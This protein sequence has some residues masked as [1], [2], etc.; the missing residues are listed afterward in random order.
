[1]R[2]ATAF[3]TASD[4]FSRIIVLVACNLFGTTYCGGT[5]YGTVFEIVKTGNAYA[6][7]PVTL[8]SFNRK[9]GANPNGSLIFDVNGNL[10][11]TTT[12]GTNNYGTVFQIVNTADAS[13]FI[14]LVNFN[15]SNGALPYGDLL[16]MPTATCSASHTA[17][18][19]STAQYSR[20]LR[21]GDRL[22]EV[23]RGFVGHRNLR[24]RCLGRST[25]RAADCR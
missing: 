4:E 24:V 1:M 5:G 9:N 25:D 17:T 14:T 13:T 16:A 19:R 20:S 10:F 23:A 22:A 11:G 12:F 7:T 18:G 15:D 2:R 3:A 21:R 6:S 8:V